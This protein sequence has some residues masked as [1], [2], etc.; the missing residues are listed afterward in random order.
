MRFRSIGICATNIGDYLTRIK[1][2]EDNYINESI[3]THIGFISLEDN[4]N[5]DGLLGPN[6]LYK[7]RRVK[8]HRKRKWRKIFKSQFHRKKL[9][10]HL[11]TDENSNDIKVNHN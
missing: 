2:V 4:N 7:L 9:H 3:L 5:K 10:F 1:E 8:N 6:S 11:K